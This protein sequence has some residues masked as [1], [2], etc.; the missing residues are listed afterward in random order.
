[1]SPTL[2]QLDAYVQRTSES[3]RFRYVRARFSSEVKHLLTPETMD[4]A[5][6]Q[7][8]D[9]YHLELLVHF[10]GLDQLGDQAP[11]SS[12]LVGFADL[13]GF[14]HEGVIRSFRRAQRQLEEILLQMVPAE[15]PLAAD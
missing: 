5:L 15:I 8:K 6:R 10:Y 2:L 14:T 4:E 1:M 9:P 7:I 13:Y 3:A 12:D 11:D